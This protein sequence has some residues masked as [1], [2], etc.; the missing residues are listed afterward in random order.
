VESTQ[1]EPADRSQ[2]SLITFTI[3]P[4]RH[5]LYAIIH[6]KGYVVITNHIVQFS[7]MPN[8]HFQTN[9]EKMSILMSDFWL[10]LALS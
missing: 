1:L 9:A 6:E 8:G 2:G 10:L 3:F 5:H 4:S 7:Q